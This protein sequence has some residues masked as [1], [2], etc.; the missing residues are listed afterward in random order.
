MTWEP[1]Q[2]GLEQIIALLKQSQSPDTATQ[3]AVQK[4]LQFFFYF[5]FFQE[6]LKVK[7]FVPRG[8][9]SSFILIFFFSD[10]SV[11]I[12]IIFS[13]YL[14]NHRLIFYVF[15]RIDNILLLNKNK[16]IIFKQG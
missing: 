4:V 10:L 13:P 2:E 6:V 14:I 9:F 11:Y 16:L 7:V 12:I 3:R 15:E 5:N 1:R 8:V